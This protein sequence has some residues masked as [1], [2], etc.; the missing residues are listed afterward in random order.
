MCYAIINKM[1]GDKLFVFLAVLLAL[2]LVSAGVSFGNESYEFGKNYAPGESLSGWV[3]VS[4]DDED[5]RS[6][7]SAFGEN[8]SIAE[9]LSLNDIDCSSSDQCSCFPLDCRPGYSTL[10]SSSESE[11]YSLSLFGTRLFGIKIEGNVSQ[12]TSFGF[13]VSTDAGS[14]CFKPL[15]IDL[16]DDDEVEWV[17]EEKGEEVC[18]IENPYGCFN[19]ADVVSQVVVTSAPFCEKIVLPPM[20]Y[21]RVGTKL[22]GTG[23]ATFHMTLNAEGVGGTCRITIIANGGAKSCDIE[24]DETLGDYIEA[25]VCLYADESNTNLYNVS[26]EDVDV[27]GYNEDNGQIFHH[28]FE[29]YARP[30]KYKGVEDFRFDSNIFEVETNLSGMVWDYVDD[31]YNGDCDPECII[32]IKIYSGILQ[33]LRIDDS[34]L[35]YKANGLE[36]DPITDFYSLQE[37]SASFNSGFIKLQVDDAKLSVPSSVGK[38]DLNFRIGGAGIDSEINVK[39]VP[40]IISLFPTRPALL[41]PTKFVAVMEGLI[42]NE[43]YQYSW[44]FGDGTLP[45]VSIDNVMEYTYSAKDS[46]T[47]T[48]NVSSEFGDVSRSFPVSVVTPYD[49]IN[50]T[51]GKYKGDLD[52]VESSLNLIPSW[53]QDEILEIND[54][55][56]LRGA[57]DR[58]EKKYKGTLIDEDE[59]LIKI[60]NDLVILKIPNDLRIGQSVNQADFVQSKE[61]LDLVTLGELGAGNVDEDEVKYYDPINAWIR[62]NID[63]TLESNTYF[64][65]YEGGSSD[66]LVSHIKLVMTPRTDVEE[67]FIVLEGSS[68][69][70]KL[71]G[72]YREKDLDFGYGLRFPELASGEAKT[73][74]FLIPEIVEVVDPPIYASPEFRNLEFSFEAGVCNNNNVCEENAGET[75]K[76]CRADCK[77]WSLTLIFLFILIIITLVVYIVLQ[78]WY[79]RRYEG[80]L[81]KNS[82]QLFNLM[83]FM[84]NAKNAGMTKSQIY[85]KLRPYKWRKEQMDYV[86]NKLQGKR[87]G[88]WEIPIFRSFEKKKIKKEMDRR[89]VSNKIVSRPAGINPVK[90]KKKGWFSKFF[91]KKEKVKK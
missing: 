34:R 47:I 44:D 69:D 54:I 87:T 66:V 10:G 62:Q 42:A 88:M 38:H 31:K 3:N 41:V 59:E 12:I 91:K 55:D 71:M 73:V 16:L 50:D 85:E 36:Q 43:S 63:M 70:I 48:L 76:N 26:V 6:L 65:Y 49:A 17:S 11:T 86:W 61:R 20:K 37:N 21:F 14:S 82:N 9:L 84:S 83:A 4:F 18:F 30:L 72:D 89:G 8:V 22:N 45:K 32:P 67:F 52:K 29:I 75:Y 35:G 27:C 56:S 23:D 46:Y 74:E 80:H 2:N 33:N 64:L 25:D 77:P 78:E 13:N 68:S 57:V 40:S 58:L 51:I 15:M 19:E 24:L 39:N 81:F 7:V 60:M 90:E 1:R 28:D 53:I 79:K 5:E